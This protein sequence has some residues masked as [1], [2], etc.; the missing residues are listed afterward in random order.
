MAA[1]SVLD[2]HMEDLQ[3]LVIGHVDRDEVD[4]LLWDPMPGGSGL[5]DQICE[6]FEE[7]ASN[8]VTI[9]ESCPSACDTSC[10][11]CLQTFRNGYY[12]KHLNRAA[13]RDCLKSRGLRLSLSHE[14]PGR[15][16]SKE[17]SDGD[18]P[19]NEAERRLR[20]LLKA[21]GFE[22]GIRGE[23]MVLDRAIGTTT[24]DIIYRASHHDKDE[25][26]CIYLDGLS[27]HI[28]GNPET[29]KQDQRIRPWL[30]NNGYDVIEIAVSDLQ[31][32]GAM[33]RH[34]RRLAG[35][36]REDK[37]RETLRKD[38]SWFKRAEESETYQGEKD[39]RWASVIRLVIPREEEKFVTCIP[40]YTLKAAAG[41]FSEGQIPEVDG[42]VEIDTSRRIRKGM[43]VGQVVGRSMEPRI[44]DGSYCLFS[45]PVEGSRQ[46]KIVLA[47]HHEMSDPEHGGSYTIK[48]YQSKKNVN[49]DETWEHEEVVLEPLNREFE[50]LV[51]KENSEDL[52]IIAELIEVLEDSVG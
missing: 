21:A 29:A 13:A 8:A 26:I 6:R 18:Y 44:S 33:V 46:G 10:I 34:F 31:D 42:W 11:D 50:P 45:Y 27:K 15:Q 25:G 5:I 22:E 3:I 41:A 32:E 48:R 17:P 30:R 43:F 23:Q 47:Q 36:L 12:H 40:L 4:G 7:I 35:C 1:T 9:V 38:K 52:K 14:I 16:P 2:M 19:V 49:P 24:P 39:R 20:Y 28:H 51:F 37:L